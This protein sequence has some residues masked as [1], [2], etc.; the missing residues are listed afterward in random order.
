MIDCIFFTPMKGAPRNEQQSLCY[1]CDD[2]RAVKTAV[3]KKF[4]SRLVSLEA[5]YVFTRFTVDSKN[6]LCIHWLVVGC[7][8]TV[9]NRCGLLVLYVL[10]THIQTISYR[11]CY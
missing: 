4:A 11:L 8:S 1:I 3:L 7:V 5:S 9:Y 6:V 2:C 10:I